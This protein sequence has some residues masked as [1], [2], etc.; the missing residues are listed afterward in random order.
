MS[1]RA[2]A[3]TR[4]LTL[5]DIHDPRARVTQQASSGKTSSTRVE[6]VR[7]LTAEDWDEVQRTYDPAPTSLI[8]RRV[9]LLW[10][11][12]QVSRISNFESKKVS[13]KTAS[14]RK[15]TNN[16]VT[17]SVKTMSKTKKKEE[18][19]EEIVDAKAGGTQEQDNAALRVMEKGAHV[20]S[21]WGV[22]THEEPWPIPEEDK[23]QYV[24][25]ELVSMIRFP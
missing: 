5:G 3:P 8:G 4:E 20:L 9:H 13:P 12:P 22:V 11:T 17:K 10:K 7:Y 18:E 14:R 19:E 25:K 24:P 2:P 23:A 15:E 16:F 1:E 21:S 6:H